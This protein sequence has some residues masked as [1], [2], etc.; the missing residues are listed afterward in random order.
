MKILKRLSLL[1]IF[2]LCAI[3]AARFCHH[4]THGFRLTKI[5]DNLNGRYGTFGDVGDSL[6]QPFRYYNRGLQSFVFLSEDGQYILKLFNNRYQRKIAFYD[7][8]A[9]IPLCATWARAQAEIQ[10]IKLKRAF[11]SYQIAATELKQET[12]LLY[13]HLEATEILP[14]SLIVIDN[15]NIAHPVNPNTLGFI[16][17]QRAA[18]A[19]PEL[20]RLIESDNQAEAKQRIC[21]LIDLLL[22]R[23]RKGIADNDPL[24]RTNFGFIDKT[25]VEVDVGPF[26]KDE[27]RSLPE[28]YRP[29]ILQ[30]TKN[31]RHWLDVNEPSLIPFLEQQLEEKV[32]SLHELD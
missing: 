22:I 14:S 19:Y 17:Q 13:A 12:A 16:I 10:R 30:I 6:N 15:L 5:Q 32:F 20:K 29:E 25:A 28:N 23:C 4:Q 26:S 21:S 1:S 31:L 27:T 8:L 3:G 2:A 24:I 11:T 18:M 7:A 9:H